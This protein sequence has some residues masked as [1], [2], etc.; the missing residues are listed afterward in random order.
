MVLG[1]GD[2]GDT[3]S[4]DERSLLAPGAKSARASP[5]LESARSVLLAL[6]E[7][8]DGRNSAGMDGIARWNGYLDGMH[9]VCAV[10]QYYAG[11]MGSSEER[12]IGADDT[13]TTAYIQ[14]VAPT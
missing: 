1:R 14:H 12:W 4:D 7:W 11:R 3:S 9:V 8:M 2:T 13:T 10:L 5:W 6:E